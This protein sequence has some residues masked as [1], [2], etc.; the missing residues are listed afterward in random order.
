[1]LSFLKEIKDWTE[2]VKWFFTTPIG[3][4][5]SLKFKN[6]VFLQWLSGILLFLL[7][8]SLFI[9]FKLCK[10]QQKELFDVKKENNGLKTKLD[11]KI[12][13]HDKKI[14]EESNNL[15]P[16]NSLKSFIN[17]NLANGYYWNEEFDMFNNFYNYFQQ[18]GHTYLN[19]KINLALNDLTTELNHLINFITRNFFPQEVPN[20]R[21]KLAPYRDENDREQLFKQL[22]ESINFLKSKYNKYRETIKNELLI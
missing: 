2:W 10:K 13:E 9:S 8:V 6:L 19:K 20:T 15:M 22:K 11:E 18:T 14:F 16:E 17:S 4:F 3:L 12:I 21:M 5:I 7:T 1:M